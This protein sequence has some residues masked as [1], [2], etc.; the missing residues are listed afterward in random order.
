MSPSMYLEHED[1]SGV[2]LVYRSNR[3]GFTYYLMGQYKVSL[4]GFYL[5]S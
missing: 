5:L 1:E 3:A 2:V 4:I